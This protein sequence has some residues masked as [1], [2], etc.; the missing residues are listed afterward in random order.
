MKTLSKSR[1]VSGM[2]CH[3]KVWFDF[4]RKDLKTPV[5]EAQQRIFDL[6]HK[7]GELAWRKFPDGKDATPEDYSDFT[8]SIANTKQWIS[9][10]VPTIYEATFSA[11]NVFCML[12]IL[13]KHQDE[14][15][16]IE[17]KNSTNVKDYHLTDAAFQYFVMAESGFIP[18]RFF[19]MHINNQYVKDGE[20]TSDIFHLE[21]ITEKVLETQP[22]VIENLDAI[23]QALELQDEPQITISRQCGSP[24]TCDYQHHCWSHIPENSVFELSRIGKNL[25]TCTNKMF[26]QLMIFPK[27]IPYRIFN[28][29]NFAEANLVK[30][31]LM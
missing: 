24:F 13:H 27:I 9:E 30:N 14:Y 23:L 1:F 12:D 22:W 10:G 3:K 5:D 2:Q 29:Y 28:N 6:G 20:I 31:I 19:L 15:W 18:D 25:G 4:Y 16:D 7:I 17:V 11:R 8:P 21:D 26:Y